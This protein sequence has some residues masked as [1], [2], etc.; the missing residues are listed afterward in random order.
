MDGLVSDLQ[1]QINVLG[2][3]DTDPTS[4]VTGNDFNCVLDAD[5]TTICWGTDTNGEATPPPTV[6]SHIAAGGNH[7]CGLGG[8][9]IE[10]WGSNSDGQGTP[11]PGTFQKVT[12]N[13]SSNH[14]CGHFTDDTVACW[15]NNFLGQVT[16]AHVGT[17]LDVFSGGANGC[18]IKNDQTLFCWGN[19]GTGQSTEPPGTF[20]EVSIGGT[21]SCGIKTDDTIVCWGEGLT[22]TGSGLERGQSIPPPG[23][24]SDIEVGALHS[25][26]LAGDGTPTCWGSDDF[27]QSTP[28]PGE[29]FIDISAGTGHTCGL[30]TSGTVRCWGL[31]DNGQS[32]V[33]NSLK[34]PALQTRVTGSCSAGDSIQAIDENGDVTCEGGLGDTS[35]PGPSDTCAAGDVAW[36][37]SYVYICV[38][39][40]S[41]KRAALTVY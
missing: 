9:T 14:T 3:S 29:T 7:A 33:P 17:A 30:R 28:P 8:G 11:P 32:T 34:L 24:F 38:G 1:D 18:V 21:H 22:D 26:A 6:F 31:D 2:S 36:D 35:S 37:A 20:A 16:D 4:I 39:I 5:G 27:G 13:L 41:W 10:C 25:C 12:A 15:G 19:F 40:D 23:T